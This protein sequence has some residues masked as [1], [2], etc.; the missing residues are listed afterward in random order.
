MAWIEL[1]DQLRRHEALAWML[2]RFGDRL[3]IPEVI[4]LP[5]EIGLA[6]RAGDPVSWCSTVASGCS[7]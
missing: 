2:Y 3:D 5:S 1:L 7:D 4:L 6:Y